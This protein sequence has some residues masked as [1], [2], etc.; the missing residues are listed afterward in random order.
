MENI[1]MKNMINQYLSFCAHLISELK[2]F[3]FFIPS[4][5]FSVMKMASQN[6]HLLFFLLLA[7]FFTNVISFNVV[8]KASLMYPLS[9]SQQIYTCNSYLYHIS[10]GLT[11]DQ[12]ASFYSVNASDIQPIS[13]GLKQDYLVSAPCTCKDVN[14]TRGYFY[15]TSYGVQAGDTFMN[16]TRVLY[17]GQA[18]KVANEEELFVAGDRIS[19][20][21]LCGCIQVQSQEIVTYTVQENDT[22]SGIAELLSANLSGIQGLNER[23]TR[24]PGYIDVGWVLFIP[25]EKNGVQAQKRGSPFSLFRVNILS[26]MQH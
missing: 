3:M 8:S 12:I 2:N 26:Y 13:H 20:H 11:I 1:T 21:L 18:W 6:H 9:C 17:S 16:I 15:D 25:K 24:N 23:L 22:L 7:T 14:G 4:H 19:I 5:W 10:E